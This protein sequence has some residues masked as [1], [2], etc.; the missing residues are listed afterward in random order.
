MTISRGTV[1]TNFLVWDFFPSCN[2]KRAPRWSWTSPRRRSDFSAR[3]WR[4]RN[5]ETGVHGKNRHLCTCRWH[6]LTFSIRNH[7]PIAALC[8]RT[9]LRS[10]C[11][12]SCSHSRCDQMST[13][14]RCHE[15][16]KHQTADKRRSS[17]DWWWQCTVWFWLLHFS[18]D[19][20]R[21]RVV[22]W[23]SFSGP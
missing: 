9:S 17:S 7:L 13:W 2:W 3:L 20:L 19:F 12:S 23:T 21:I 4:R 5:G 11:R 8:R 18:S 16:L 15:F 1:G 22:A 10:S 6:L 14:T